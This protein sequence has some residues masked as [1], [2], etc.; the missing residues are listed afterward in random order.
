M[1]KKRNCALL[2]VNLCSCSSAILNIWTLPT[3]ESLVVM[4]ELAVNYL[5][6]RASLT[7]IKMV[8][9]WVERW[10]SSPL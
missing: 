7:S 6:G 4:V 2:L 1:E 10:R 8:I 9:M 3:K 5:D